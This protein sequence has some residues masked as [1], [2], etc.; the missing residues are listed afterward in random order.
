M[1]GV[2]PSVPPEKPVRSA[3]NVS[4]TIR[5]TFGGPGGGAARHALSRPARHARSSR[6]R[7][8]SVRLIVWPSFGYNCGPPAS[9]AARYSSRRP[10]RAWWPRDATSGPGSDAGSRDA[11]TGP[12]RGVRPLRAAVPEVVVALVATDGG[13]E[14]GPHAARRDVLPPAPPLEGHRAVGTDQLAR[15]GLRFRSPEQAARGP[16]ARTVPDLGEAAPVGGEAT[17]VVLL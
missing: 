10:R 16:E 6:R 8:M 5:I 1:N 2:S 12:R 11:S 15:V 4:A 17:H 13:P 14:D 9:V 3:R 7:R